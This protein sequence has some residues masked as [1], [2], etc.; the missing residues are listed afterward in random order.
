MPADLSILDINTI[1]KLN[2]LS[3]S[4]EASLS[5]RRRLAQAR[6]DLLRAERAR[7]G[8]LRFGES[9]LTNPIVEL[10][11]ALGGRH[12]ASGSHRRAVSVGVG[13]DAA[14][15]AAEVDGIADPTLVSNPSQLS[16]SDIDDLERSLVGYEELL[17]T[18]RRALHREIDRLHAEL[19][20]RLRGALGGAWS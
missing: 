17:S 16:L 13:V 12:R 1:R 5:Y 11:E 9:L 6:I 10:A 20:V 15:L 18:Q 8:R 3:Q 19:V 14:A 2:R 4:Q 7:R